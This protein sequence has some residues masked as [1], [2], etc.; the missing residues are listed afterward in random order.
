MEETL[1][2]RIAKQRK[3]MKLT[4]NELAEKLMVSNKAISKWE[5]NKGNPSI[6]F[7]PNLSKIL[8]CT[9]DYLLLGEDIEIPKPN[10]PIKLDIPNEYETYED[11]A[12][13][14]HTLLYC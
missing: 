11:L 2:Y 8:C 3:K 12:K 4:Q 5:S 6:E 9:T 13:L 7:L 1:G 14:S 10:I